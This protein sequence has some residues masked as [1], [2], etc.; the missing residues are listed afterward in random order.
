MFNM[1]V[2]VSFIYMIVTNSMRYQYVFVFMLFLCFI[3]QFSKHGNVCFGK[4]GVLVSKIRF[5]Q[6]VKYSVGDFWIFFLCFQTIEHRI[7]VENRFLCC[8]VHICIYS[9]LIFVSFNA[10]NESIDEEEKTKSQHLEISTSKV[11]NEVI[12]KFFPKQCNVAG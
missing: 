6:Q 7:P 2:H 1:I 5:V 10:A 12:L 11:K 3:F 8:T 9:N 4:N